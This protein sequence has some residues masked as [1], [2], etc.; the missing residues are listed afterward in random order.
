MSI[1][2]R[3][4]TLISDRQELVVVTGAGG[5]IGG[6]LVANLREQGYERIR[7]VDV[8][9]LDEWY[10]HFSDVENLC[11]DL[12]LKGSCERTA[13]GVSVPMEPNG[14]APDAAMGVSKSFRS[15]SV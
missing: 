5:F 15:S 6:N 8:K 3:E 11:L 13:D 7:A 14:S 9:P 12:N 1:P 10:Q 4:E 2:K